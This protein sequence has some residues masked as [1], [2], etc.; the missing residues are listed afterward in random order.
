MVDQN[1]L[2]WFGKGVKSGW[3]TR[4]ELEMLQFME[5]EYGTLSEQEKLCA[6][7][8]SLF[9]N[10]GHTMLPLDRTA[11]QWGKLLDIPGEDLELLPDERITADDL[12][13]GKLVTEEDGMKPLLLRDNSLAFRRY[14][15]FEKELLSKIEKKNNPD[16]NPYI[17]SVE[18]ELLNH[19]F[20]KSDSENP[21]WQKTAAA[22]SLI[23]PF[24]I[25]S[26]G[27]GT[28]KTTTVARLLVL[29]QR[30]NGGNLNI[31]LAAPTGK[32]AGRMGEA[33]SGEIAKLDLSEEEISGIP[34]EAKTVHRLLWPMRDEGL[35]PPAET[36]KLN[37][38]LVIV[39][40]ASMVDLSLMHRLFTHLG[41]NTRLI[42]LGDKH[43]LA[44]VEAGAVFADLCRKQENGFT[45]KTISLL[46]QLG[47]TGELLQYR[48]R[49]LDDAIVYLTKSFRFDEKS[50]IGALAAAIKSTKNNPV[51]ILES[52]N[53]LDHRPFS[54]SGSDLKN[55]TVHFEKRIKEARLADNPEMML[56][57]WKKEAWFTVLR[58]GLSGSEKLNALVE[59]RAASSVAAGRMHGWYHGRP[60]IITKNDYDLG[61][62][63]GDIGVCFKRENEDTH[64]VYVESGANLKKIPADRL[65]HAEP[66]YFLTVHKSQGSEFENVN[67]LL[68][69]ADTSILTREL[70]YTAVTRAKKKFTLHG[71]IELF[72]LG[73]SRKTERFTMLGM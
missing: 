11:R 12:L 16:E 15:L 23:K 72:K 29:H 33:L 41:E 57:Y 44:S 31:A 27:P 63:N 60:V 52:F 22:L 7:F 10:T 58:R 50:G 43:Q 38:D 53:D 14:A 34:Q 48:G 4:Y 66:A 71:S 70:L 17:S 35:L 32:A 56:S 64:F 69:N 20:R 30:L 13:N 2:N 59:Q 3:I 54:Y 62:F 21:D 39:D 24:L 42:L 9:V 5:E 26:G 6:V 73:I 28:G 55:L 47:I 68:P 1:I 18:P 37:Y 61:V 67:L 65:V 45:V 36:K 8:T 25:I 19:L 49:P 51:K 46:K 40:E